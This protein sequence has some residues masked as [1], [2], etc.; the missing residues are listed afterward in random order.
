M[1]RCFADREGHDHLA[2]EQGV[3][4]TQFAIFRFASLTDGRPVNSQIGTATAM[5]VAKCDHL[6]QT[7]NRIQKESQR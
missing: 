7:L 2:T 4:K 1:P 6:R 5:C 3:Q